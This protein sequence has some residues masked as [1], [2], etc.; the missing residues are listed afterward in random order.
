MSLETKIRIKSLFWTSCL[1]VGG[2]KKCPNYR[3]VE[4]S[5]IPTDLYGVGFGIY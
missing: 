2:L 4:S 1:G 3:E 5:Q